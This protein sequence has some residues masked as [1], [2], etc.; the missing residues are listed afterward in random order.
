MTENRPRRL[1][2]TE[3]ARIP[4]DA[5]ILGWGPVLV[6]PAGALWIW[7]GGPEWLAPAIRLWGAAVALFLSGVRRGLSFRM[8]GGWTWAQM[9]MFAWLF[10][11]GL[12]ALLLP[13]ELALVLL[14]VIYA[15]LALL[16]PLAAS[17]EEAPLWFRRLRP[18][19]MGVAAVGL[20]AVW[21][22]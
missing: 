6:F 21:L 1:T 10:W 18:A 20:A 4:W 3:P 19:Q 7:L 14:V 5:V 11:A 17:R 8:P 12:A 16:D 9:A 15:S 22:G 2:V 13:L